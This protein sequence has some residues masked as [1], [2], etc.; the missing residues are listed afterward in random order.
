M[1]QEFASKVGELDTLAMA[2]EPTNCRK[3]KHMGAAPLHGPYTFCDRCGRKTHAMLGMN[4]PAGL[5]IFYY[6]INL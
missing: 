2:L 3:C 1:D 6:P 4:V 5:G